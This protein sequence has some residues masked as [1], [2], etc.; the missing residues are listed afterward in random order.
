MHR[1]GEGEVYRE[2]WEGE[3]EW[4]HRRGWVEYIGWEEEEEWEGR[5][6][7]WVLRGKG[8]ATGLGGKW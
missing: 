6:R 4:M 1:R 2:W 3:E 5:K 8:T 7:T